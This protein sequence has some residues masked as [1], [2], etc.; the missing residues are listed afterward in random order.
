MEGKTSDE[1]FAKMSANY[2]EEQRCLEIRSVEIKY[3]IAT[4]KESSSKGIGR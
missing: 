1:C 3:L 2:K 4:E